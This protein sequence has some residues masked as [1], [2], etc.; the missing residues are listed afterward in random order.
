MAD[1]SAIDSHQWG[2]TIMG[3]KW[4]GER[5]REGGREEVGARLGL[6]MA[7]LPA[8][9]NIRGFRIRWAWIRVRNLA[10]G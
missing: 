6:G 3:R 8:G 5:E 7:I 4:G 9:T 10:H 1:H 2:V